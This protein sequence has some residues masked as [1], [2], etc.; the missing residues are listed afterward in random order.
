MVAERKSIAPFEIIE[1]Q[2]D[3]E[4]PIDL[5][6]FF[7]IQINRQLEDSLIDRFYSEWTHL[8]WRKQSNSL[9]N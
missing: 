6:N 8:K 7:H 3:A 4:Q 1:F 9:S 5:V 2:I